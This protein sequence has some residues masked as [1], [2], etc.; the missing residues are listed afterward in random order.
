VLYSA[1]FELDILRIIR[2]PHTVHRSGADSMADVPRHILVTGVSRGLGRALV[3]GLAQ[4]G[5]IIAGCARDAS[6]I[7]QLSHELGTPHVFSVVDV[8]Q[9][10]QVDQWA[11]HL[12]SEWGTPELLLNNAA[13]INSNA[14]L[15]EVDA[16]EFSQL[17][18]VNIKGVVHV[19]RAFLPAMIAAGRGVVVN[20]SSGWGRSAAAEVAPYCASKWAIEGL[21]QSLAQEL[22]EG[23][24]AVPVN[25]GIIDTQMLRR[26]FGDGAGCYPSAQEWARKAVPFLL[27]LGVKHNG[28]PVTV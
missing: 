26:C 6:Q 23:L 1:S 24:S 25:P 8:A 3:D 7:S 10:T 22:P 27:D 4:R 15:W 9:A 21:T 5:H 12:L 14:P 19:I 17:I 11:Q 18:D 28:R 16:E 2:P 20:F 13:L